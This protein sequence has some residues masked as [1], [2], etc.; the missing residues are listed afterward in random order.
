M[1]TGQIKMMLN[2]LLSVFIV[3]ALMLAPVR[4]SVSVATN[5]I[6]GMAASMNMTGCKDHP[7]PCEKAKAPCDMKFGCAMACVYFQANS[8]FSHSE[9][10]TYQ[11]DMV[12]A[13]DGNSLLSFEVVPLR[14]PPRV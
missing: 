12:F 14:R 4:A 5:D 3:L 1:V 8:N 13:F 6:S 11:D 2:A 9:T 7:C 10:I